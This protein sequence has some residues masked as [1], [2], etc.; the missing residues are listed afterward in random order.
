MTANPAGKRDEGQ[1]RFKQMQARIIQSGQE[2]HL[3]RMAHIDSVESGFGLVSQEECSLPQFLE[4]LLRASGMTCSQLARKA[5][6]NTT[7]VYD[8]FKGKSRPGRDN[9]LMLAFALNCNVSKTQYLLRLAGAA[10]L[11]PSIRRDVTIAWHIAHGCTREE[12]DDELYRL[13]ETTLL[14]PGIGLD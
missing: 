12:C 3:E 7:F 13:G 6:V 10:A 8:I 11:W 4:E 2:E 5:C 1:G 9:A 14:K